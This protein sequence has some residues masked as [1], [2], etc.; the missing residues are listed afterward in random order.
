MIPQNDFLRPTLRDRPEI[1]TY[2]Y[3]VDLKMFINIYHT[4]G[5][6]IEYSFFEIN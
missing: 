5:K 6:I 2:E 1:D 3:M 4:F